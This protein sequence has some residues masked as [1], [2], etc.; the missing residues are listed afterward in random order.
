MDVGFNPILPDEGVVDISQDAWESF[1]GA[2]EDFG[3]GIM[4][5]LATRI[6]PYLMERPVL[7]DW[8]T[9]VIFGVFA[10]LSGFS[11]WSDWNSKYALLGGA[12]AALIVLIGTMTKQLAPIVQRI[13]SYIMRNPALAVVIEVISQLVRSLLEL[14]QVL[15]RR[16]VDV[17]EAAFD[18]TILVIAAGRAMQL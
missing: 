10:G 12:F 3:L 4:K 8:V 18:A 7:P 9:F 1:L 15:I 11:V 5:I 2:A 16:L 14:V 6:A 13:T 17:F